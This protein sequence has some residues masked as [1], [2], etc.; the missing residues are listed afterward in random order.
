MCVL[1]LRTTLARSLLSKLTACPWFHSNNWSLTARVFYY[2]V[3]LLLSLVSHSLF[4]SL[5]LSN[6]CWAIFLHMASSL[7]RDYLKNP[8]KVAS[9]SLESCNWAESGSR[10]RSFLPNGRV[11]GLH[12]VWF[13]GHLKVHTP[14]LVMMQ[15]SLRYRIDRVWG[16]LKSLE[17]NAAC[18]RY[19]WAPEAVDFSLCWPRGFLQ[20]SMTTAPCVLFVCPF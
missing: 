16:A 18:R 14:I 10:C 20:W 15:S 11:A 4:F 19:R 12:C 9:R 3:F 2:G 7:K 8:R 17:M 5:C 6:S 13:K 1:F